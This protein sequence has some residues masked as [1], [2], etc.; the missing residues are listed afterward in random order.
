ML[1]EGH[2]IARCTVA[3][4]MQKMGLQGVIRGKRVCTTI[5]DKAARLEEPRYA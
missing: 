2:G 3:R 1:C 4:L 5:S